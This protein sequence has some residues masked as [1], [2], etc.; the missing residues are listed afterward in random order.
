[1]IVVFTGI[2]FY[3]GATYAPTTITESVTTTVT[4]M[5]TPPPE[6][7]VTGNVSTTGLGTS[8]TKITFTSSTTGTSYQGQISGSTY[9]VTLRNEDTYNVTI[10]WKTFINSGTCAAGTV[11]LFVGYGEPR[12]VTANWSC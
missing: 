3:L 11:A 4:T 10:G 5:P 9:T 8:P 12:T 7:S 1:M 2:G 6:A